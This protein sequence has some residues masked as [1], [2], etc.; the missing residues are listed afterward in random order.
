[1]TGVD[2]LL[3]TARGVFPLTW[4]GA[5][6][7]RALHG[8]LV[9]PLL[10]SEHLNSIQMCTCGLPQLLL[11]RFRDHVSGT[12]DCRE[13]LESVDAKSPSRVRLAATIF[14]GQRGNSIRVSIPAFEM[15][16]CPTI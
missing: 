5:V 15:D 12:G 11:E 9:M 8:G 7:M 1:M 14:A 10:Q 6:N 3:E 16:C 13:H 2:A 4:P